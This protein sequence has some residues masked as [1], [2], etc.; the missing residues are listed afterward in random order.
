MAIAIT[1][2]GVKISLLITAGSAGSG[3]YL[4]VGVTARAS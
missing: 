3:N 4:C 1:G 2:L